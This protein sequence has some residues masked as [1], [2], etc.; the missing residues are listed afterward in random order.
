MSKFASRNTSL[1][2]LLYV[3]SGA[4][5]P[6]GTHTTHARLAQSSRKGCISPRVT[7][8][9]PSHP[10]LLAHIYIRL[11][12]HHNGIFG[13]AMCRLSQPSDAERKICEAWMAG[14]HPLDTPCPRG[15]KPGCKRERRVVTTLQNNSDKS[16]LEIEQFTPINTYC[17][18][19]TYN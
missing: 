2:L 12:R 9:V 8:R 6:L 3:Y 15:V 18:L 7:Y 19:L 17:I 10:F 5:P 16:M 14:A 4:I 11:S 13:I 1:L